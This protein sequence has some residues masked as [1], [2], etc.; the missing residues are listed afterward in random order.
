[1]KKKNKNIPFPTHN[2]QLVALRRIEGQIRGVQ[3]MIEKNRYCVDILTQLYSIMGA[4]LRVRDKVLKR[5]IEGC[6]V[7]AI[8]GKSSLHKQKKIDEMMELL[9]K[10]RNG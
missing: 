6:V 10:F 4:I 1:M 7:N 2:E 5:H 8:K 3:K 9:T